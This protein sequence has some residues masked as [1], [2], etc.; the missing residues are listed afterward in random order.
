MYSKVSIVVTALLY[1]ILLPYME[2]SDTHVFSS[3]WPGHARMHDVWQLATNASLALLALWQGVHRGK[4]LLALAIDW[5]ITTAFV[6]AYAI[7]GSYGGDMLYT[8][9]EE[10]IIWGVNPAFGIMVVMSLVLGAAFVL[11]YRTAQSEASETQ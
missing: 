2:V 6:F 10:L 8:N 3:S 7:R 11:E 5:L 1:V 9:G 4:M